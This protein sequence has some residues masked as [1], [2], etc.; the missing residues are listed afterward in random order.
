MSDGVLAC[1]G[2]VFRDVGLQCLDLAC[3]SADGVRRR[4]HEL[5]HFVGVVSFTNPVRVERGSFHVL[6]VSNRLV[7]GSPLSVER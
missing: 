4:V 6:G 1:Y 7:T 5:V 2:L 3:Q